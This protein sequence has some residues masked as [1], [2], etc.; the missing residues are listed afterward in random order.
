MTSNHDPLTIYCPA[1]NEAFLG[2][3]GD[4]C[5]PRCGMQAPEHASSS[6][7]T[8]HI[9]MEDLNPVE[10]DAHGK[11]DLHHLSGTE[12]DRYRL[13]SLLGK[14]GMGWVF[15]AQHQ[16]LNRP[17]AVKILSPSLVRKDPDY[18]ER[19]HVEG[20]AAAS[21]NHANI[22]TIHAIGQSN[23]R[24]FLEMEF[25]PGRSLQ[26]VVSENPLLPTRAA[27]IAL[28]IANGLAAAHR[29]GIVHRDLKPDNVLLTH[30]GIPKISD[31]GLA[32]RLHGSAV[33]EGPGTLAGTPHFMAPELFLGEPAT[34]ASDV[35]ALG[36]S[37]FVMITGRVPFTGD[38]FADLAH[39]IQHDAAP[40]IRDLKPDVPLELCECLGLMM[41]KS[42]TNRPANGIEASQLLQAV[43]GQVRDVESL[44]HTAF[45]HEPH[46]EWVREG[47]RYRFCVTLPNGRRQIVF[48][49]TSDHDLTE[50]LLQIYS[51]CC[52]AES[53]FHR[54]AL[55]LNSEIP[56]GAIALRDINGTEYFVTLNNYPLGTV[57]AEEIRRSVLELAEYADSIELKL[58]GEDRN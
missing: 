44:L 10:F 4:S 48:V 50:R 12:I 15:L 13:Q 56:H 5:C 17:C 58:T 1:C 57:D 24:H 11:D 49:E 40:N 18:L 16:Q 2:R 53:H 46:V 14:G 54:E 32:K 41:E 20:Q 47:A 36:V 45:D 3:L 28:G 19:F 9:S 38:G 43:L 37:L 55:R 8:I 35:Y 22:V 21:L 23:G 31:F 52:P 39:S 6:L 51:L 26:R 27:T 34:P 33:K 25:V 7:N 30:H 29:V 42:P